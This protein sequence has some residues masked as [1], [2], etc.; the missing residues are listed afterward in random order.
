[1]NRENIQ[2]T[3][4]ALRRAHDDAFDMGTWFS[5]DNPMAANRNRKHYLERNT[6]GTAACIAG[7][8]YA[9]MGAKT[10]AKIKAKLGWDEE[11]DYAA[12]WFGINLD[13][14]HSLFI[15]D[16]VGN[17]RYTRAAAIRTLEILLETGEVDWERGIAEQ[18]QVDELVERVALALAAMDSVTPQPMTATALPTVPKRRV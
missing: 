10:R 1:M 5:S 3:I 18:S 15:P 2:T 8:G 13:Q 4:D 7:W 11:Q 6:C 12:E 9:I 14:S 17:G 16:D